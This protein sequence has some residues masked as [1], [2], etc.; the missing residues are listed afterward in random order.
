MA[1]HDS[2]YKNNEAYAEHLASWDANLWVWVV[3]FKRVDA[4]A[5]QAAQ[6]A[7]AG[8]GQGQ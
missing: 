5:A 6:P 1:Q 7:D 8:R 4:A 3:T 2:Y